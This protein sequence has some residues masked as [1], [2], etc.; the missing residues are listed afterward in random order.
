MCSLTWVCIIGLVGFC[1]S[2]VRRLPWSS[3]VASKD[4]A[5][6]CHHIKQQSVKRL[7]CN[8]LFT[9]VGVIV[10]IAKPISITALLLPSD[11]WRQPNM[12]ISRLHHKQFKKWNPAGLETNITFYWTA[13]VF[14]AVT[15]R[16]NVIKFSS[17]PYQACRFCCPDSFID[18][19]TRLQLQ[20]EL[21]IFSSTRTSV[22][23][24]CC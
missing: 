21:F 11:F 13:R 18:L 6:T 9:A 23:L 3:Y 20:T 5:L 14:C 2:C 1:S 16:L 19:T 4:S 10:V 15:S 7:H 8:Q 24:T 12:E 17:S 22:T